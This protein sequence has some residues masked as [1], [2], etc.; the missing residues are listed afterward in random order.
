VVRDLNVCNIVDL[1]PLGGV[2][3][4]HAAGLY[5]GFFT[6]RWRGPVRGRFLDLVAHVR[7]QSARAKATRSY[8]AGRY[9]YRLMRWL[10]PALPRPLRGWYFANCLPLT[11]GISNLRLPATWYGG[12]LGDRVGAYWRAVPLGVLAPLALG[13]TTVRDRLTVGMTARRSGFSAQEVRAVA[14]VLVGR[15]ARLPAGGEFG[16][17]ASCVPPLHRPSPIWSP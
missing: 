5:L 4:R 2:A 17:T 14:E 7:R 12:D 10:W 16:E 9:H 3:L 8:L 6:T 13:V 1:R 15:L 11:G